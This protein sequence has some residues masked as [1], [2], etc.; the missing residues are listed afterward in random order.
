[1]VNNLNIKN[2]L[3]TFNTFNTLTTGIGYNALAFTQNFTVAQFQ[4]GKAIQNS[5]GVWAIPGSGE[6]DLTQLVSWF[7]D[8]T[9]TAFQ[10]YNSNNIT[11][12]IGYNALAFTQNFTV[13]QFQTGKAIQNLAGVWAIPGSGE[14]DLTQLVSWFTDSTN[15]ALEPYVTPTISLTDITGN[16]NFSTN[17]VVNGGGLVIGDKTSETF[18]GRVLPAVTDDHRSDN[19]GSTPTPTSYIKF[20]LN[21]NNQLEYTS[22]SST[23]QFDKTSLPAFTNAMSV[24]TNTLTATVV[25]NTGADYN[26]LIQTSKTFNHIA[27]PTFTLTGAGLASSIHFGAN[28]TKPVNDGYAGSYLYDGTS[29]SLSNLSAKGGIVGSYAGITTGAY[30]LGKS[31][32]DRAWAGYTVTV[33]HT[34]VSDQGPIT[35]TNNHSVSIA[36]PQVTVTNSVFLYP[37]QIQLNLSVTG[38]TLGDNNSGRIQIS[39]NSVAKTV[40][41]STTTQ[42]YTTSLTQTNIWNATTGTWSLE[43]YISGAYN[44]ALYYS[45]YQSQALGSIAAWYAPTSGA[46]ANVATITSASCS[47]S[48]QTKKMTIK[49][50]LPAL[51]SGSTIPSTA[52]EKIYWEILAKDTTIYAYS[53]STTTSTS[54]TSSVG[55][56]GLVDLVRGSEQTIT[57]TDIDSRSEGQYY[58]VLY[59]LYNFDKNQALKYSVISKKSTSV[60]TNTHYKRA[61]FTPN[62]GTTVVAG[63]TLDGGGSISQ[64]SGS[65]VTLGTSQYSKN[66][67][68]AITITNSANTRIFGQ[69]NSSIKINYYFNNEAQYGTINTSSR[70]VSVSAFVMTI[71]T[72]SNS[73]TAPTY[74]H[75]PSYSF[76]FGIS[77]F[78]H[79]QTN[80][81]RIGFDNTSG[82]QTYLTDYT[83]LNGQTGTTE[84]TTGAIKFASSAALT[85][86]IVLTPKP[87]YLDTVSPWVDYH[88]T[89]FSLSTALSTITIPKYVP[90]LLVSASHGN[91][92]DEATGTVQITFAL[93][94]NYLVP[95]GAGSYDTQTFV[96][97]EI[98]DSTFSSKAGTA[99]T[100]ASVAANA[101]SVDYVTTPPSI[102]LAQLQEK[103]TLAATAYTTATPK[104][105]HAESAFTAAVTA[106]NDA[107]ENMTTENILAKVQAAAAAA[108][109]AVAAATSLTSMASI[110]AAFNGDTVFSTKTDQKVAQTVLTTGSNTK[111]LDIKTLGDGDL[112]V[113]VYF[114]HNFAIE[115][116]TP[117]YC[118]IAA[119]ESDVFTHTQDKFAQS[120]KPLGF[121][122]FEGGLWI[123]I[124]ESFRTA[125]RFTDSTGTEV[126]IEANDIRLYGMGN[127]GPGKL[128]VMSG[129]VDAA[130]GNFVTTLV[131]GHPQSYQMDWVY[132]LNSPANTITLV[133]IGNYD[134]LLQLGGWTKIL[135]G[136]AVGTLT[137]TGFMVS[138]RTADTAAL[139]QLHPSRRKAATQTLITLY[140]DGA[141]DA[142]DDGLIYLELPA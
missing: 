107:G 35:T 10:P 115:G 15:T 79:G 106:F 94:A 99:N 130:L 138:L 82:T 29:T 139:N 6:A 57:P 65:N 96:Y 13:A 121:K 131:P 128:A 126:T 129:E 101:Y 28:Y 39:V 63:V 42:T 51:S 50:T 114:I 124:S 102:T 56:S 43:H 24:G 5:A 92:Y 30:P 67:A 22:Q 47:Y 75:P 59:L 33:S 4:T 41:T 12:G 113:R 2:N 72:G 95:S 17:Y 73:Y 127:L 20:T 32:S 125:S 80:S 105:T 60:M 66:T 142:V 116:A 11:T 71:G 118:I 27:A 78:K 64:S 110:G 25:D 108:V 8:S 134:T 36:T 40:W 49:Y 81:G 85:T 23:F 46:D 120:G 103:F 132:T 16:Y 112:T 53:T 89:M 109:L 45:S 137:D 55:S 38:F 84:V 48:L 77:N 117:D 122:I 69:A 14:A 104:M 31:S 76:S 90:Y 93:P 133:G 1:M 44:Y 74:S 68:S 97:M 83:A 111:T 61:I 7:T 58:V 3:E 136:T 91:T 98:I 19:K 52:H 9:N 135:T 26:P 140:S 18:S 21:G 88:E 34:T 123:K 37:P 86:N 70:T 62:Q 54:P 141:T 100:A 87:M 119:K